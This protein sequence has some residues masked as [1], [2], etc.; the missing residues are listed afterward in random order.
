[1]T[2]LGKATNSYFCCP[3]GV[4]EVVYLASQLPSATGDN[5]V[6]EDEL[7]SAG[8]ALLHRAQSVD[9]LAWAL[10]AR[11][12]PSI[13]SSAIGSRFRAGSAHRLAACLYIMQAAPPLQTSVGEEVVDVIMDDLHHTLE[14]IPSSDSNFKSTAWTTFVFGAT[15]KSEERK[16][17]V[18]DRMRQLAVAYPW[19]YLS[20]SMET[21]EILWALRTEGKLTRSWLPTL[22]DPEHNILVV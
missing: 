16:A 2:I 14:A 10:K 3:P 7:S 6:S 11:D 19:G 5:A 21:L 9:I 17:W 15:A 22:R 8:S 18:M 13:A 4:L 12:T 20:T 1:M